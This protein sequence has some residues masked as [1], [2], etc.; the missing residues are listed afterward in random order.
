VQGQATEIAIVAEHIIKLRTRMNKIL[1]EN[2]NQDFDKI[3]KDVERDF[4]MTA[5]ESKA[6][7][8]IDKVYTQREEIK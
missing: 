4:Y 1:A 2:T 5:E 7:G 3:V 6:Y 8:L